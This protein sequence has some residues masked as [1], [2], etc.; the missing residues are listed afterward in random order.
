MLINE[1]NKE[2]DETKINLEKTKMNSMTT[3]RLNAGNDSNGNPR[4]VFVTLI[5]GE[6]EATYDEN[7]RGVDAITK[8]SHREAY[9]GCTIKTSVSEY[10][11]LLTIGSK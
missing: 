3:I 1:S 9:K 4:R 2:T 8:K 10:K 7:Y 6:I 11:E 5:G